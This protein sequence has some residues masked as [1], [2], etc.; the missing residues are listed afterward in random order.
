MHKEYC[1][2]LD[3]VSFQL[4]LGRFNFRLTILP[5]RQWKLSKE[6]H[7]LFLPLREALGR[8]DDLTNLVMWNI[9]YIGPI[10]IDYMTLHNRVNNFDEDDWDLDDLTL[11]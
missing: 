11:N 3:P 7:D 2:K 5:I 6:S 8:K 10:A 1:I 9:I 4:I